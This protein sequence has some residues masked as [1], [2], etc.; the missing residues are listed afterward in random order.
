MLPFTRVRPALLAGAL[1]I[2]PT[3]LATA[4]AQQP[5]KVLPD[6][7]PRK[8]QILEQFA[9]EFITVTPGKGVFATTYLMG[10]KDVPD[11][12]PVHAVTFGGPFAMAKYEVTQELYH[13]V[14]GKN[15][16]KWLGLRNSAEMM[17]WQD[18]NTFCE[19]VHAEMPNRK[20]NAPDETIPLPTPAERTNACAPGSQTA[21]S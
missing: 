7:T 4:P 14:M 17:N 20:H 11:A 15:P 19:K 10:S 3:L 13:V 1:A 9:K 6:P 16:S 2:L 21:Y 5:T 12:T 8:D 18:A